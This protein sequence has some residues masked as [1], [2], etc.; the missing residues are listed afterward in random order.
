MNYRYILVGQTPV[1]CE[2]LLEWGH[3]FETAERRVA[4]TF[5]GD[6]EISTVFLG[7]DH[8]FLNRGEPLLFE[9]MIFFVPA[10][11]LPRNPGESLEDF[12]HRRRPIEETADQ[13]LIDWTQRYSTWLSAEIRPRKSRSPRR[14]RSGRQTHPGSGPD[15]R[16]CR[17]RHYRRYLS[18]ETR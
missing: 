10:F 6:Y 12:M 3:W 14:R 17:S 2:D 13:R 8:S 11:R 4:L 18:K 5:V 15:S 7:L 9:T 1:P 16:A